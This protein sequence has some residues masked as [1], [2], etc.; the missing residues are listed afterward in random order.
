MDSMKKSVSTKWAKISRKKQNSRDLRADE[1]LARQL[2]TL[3]TQ[4]YENAQGLA[5]LPNFTLEP[6][7][8]RRYPVQNH[9]NQRRDLRLPIRGRSDSS[10]N[11]LGGLETRQVPRP[12]ELDRRA[13]TSP[14]SRTPIVSQQLATTPPEGSASSNASSRNSDPPSAIPSNDR[15]GASEIPIQTQSSGKTA[16]QLLERVK[17]ILFV[18]RSSG[19]KVFFGPRE[20]RSDTDEAFSRQEM[21]YMRVQVSMD[22]IYR[23]GEPIETLKRSL[24]SRVFFV[25][26][27]RSVRVFLNDRLFENDNQTLQQ[28]RLGMSSFMSIV[29]GPIRRLS[30]PDILRVET[31]HFEETRECIVDSENHPIPM[32]PRR[33]TSQC[34]HVVNICQGCVQMTIKAGMEMTD[35]NKIKCP[36]PE[37]PA[38]MSHYDIKHLLTE[39][40]FQRYDTL[41]TRAYLSS[42]EQFRHCIAQGCNSGQIH[43]MSTA[44]PIFTCIDPQCGFK[45]CVLCEAEWHEGETCDQYQYRASGSKA[46]EEEVATEETIRK[47]TKSCPQCKSNIEKNEGCDHM[48]Y[49][50]S[51]G[52]ASPTTNLSEETGTPLTIGDADITRSCLCYASKT[53]E[54]NKPQH[55]FLTTGGHLNQQP[56]D[57][58]CATIYVIQLFICWLPRRIR[59]RRI[60]RR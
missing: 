59:V 48:T 54:S 51:A 47:T 36:D 19:L 46:R 2:Q 34:E 55:G 8:P 5:S 56:E 53:K 1:A 10:A 3:E 41:V 23:V 42:D 15:G 20:L 43:P 27:W 11:T 30:G 37:C 6:E 39:E 24:A 22:H 7:L 16:G 28:A 33:I 12:Q 60:G 29:S 40:D 50:N 13:A 52:S 45:F 38:V 18:N 4:R 21:H 17:E 9:S 57:S 58:E 31:L 32:F 26:D 14:T 25:S 35:W 44:S 49:M